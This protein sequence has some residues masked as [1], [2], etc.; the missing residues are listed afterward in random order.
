MKS[1]NGSSKYWQPTDGKMAYLVVTLN[2]QELDR[3]ELAGPVVIGRSG[4]AGLVVRDALISRQHCRV[5]PWRAGWR[6]V[7]LGSRNGTRV[8]I[9]RI[10]ERKLAEGDLL[11]VGR[12]EIRFLT[13]EFVPGFAT[14]GNRMPRPADPFEALAGTLAGFVMDPEPVANEPAMDQ[15]HW[16]VE[17]V[18]NELEV[19]RQT[20][21][22]TMVD[23][24]RRAA[25]GRN[26]QGSGGYGSAGLGLTGSGPTGSEQAG[27]GPMVRNNNGHVEMEREGQAVG[28]LDR[29]V[30]VQRKPVP[31]REDYSLQAGP[32]DLPVE[33]VIIAARPPGHYLLVAVLIAI[34]SA[35]VAALIVSLIFMARGQV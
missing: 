25:A 11:R 7:D 12:S 23:N 24:R 8:G 35:T 16:S 2:G 20:V 26:G 19:A 10:N 21:Q 15:E 28:E 31:T 1:L 13:G 29:P 30:R 32:E 9:D 22:Q 33:R 34:V 5:E 6:V 14:E 18:L 4:E 17:E 3:R 27:R